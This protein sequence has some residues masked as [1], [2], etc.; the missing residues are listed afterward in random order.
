VRSCCKL[1]YSPTSKAPDTLLVWGEADDINHLH[2]SL[3]ALRDD[4]ER[5]IIV[6]GCT[7]DSHLSIIAVNDRHR[8]S[9]LTRT[10]EGLFWTCSRPVIDEAELWSALYVMQPPGINSLTYLVHSRQ[11]LWSPRENI[12]RPCDP[13]DHDTTRRAKSAKSQK[14][15][16]IFRRNGKRYSCAHTPDSRFPSKAGIL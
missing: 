5:V 4:P 14:T 6:P 8:I 10:N 2:T 3:R 1:E 15:D 7:A 9:E 16:P 13:E 12:R 11:Q